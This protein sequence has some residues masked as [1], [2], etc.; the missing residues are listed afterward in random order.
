MCVKAASGAHRREHATKQ[1]VTWQVHS[2]FGEV[3]GQLEVPGSLPTSRALDRRLSLSPSNLDALA[4]SPALL[5]LSPTGPSSE[6]CSENL[7]TGT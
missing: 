6:P 7:A 3:M 2:T 5:C 1:C 4:S